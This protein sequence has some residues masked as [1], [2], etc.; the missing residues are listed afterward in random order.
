MR[1]LILACVVCQLQM[2]VFVRWPLYGK[3]SASLYQADTFC[4]FPHAG[5]LGLRFYD[6]SSVKAYLKFNF[7]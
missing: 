1:M 5:G 7:G 6:G 2:V 3:R 4:D